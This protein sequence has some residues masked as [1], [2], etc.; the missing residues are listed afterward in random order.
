M[1]VVLDANIYVS[2]AISPSGLCSQIIERLLLK[3]K[4]YTIVISPKISKEIRA[5]LSKPYILKYSGRTSAELNRWIDM[6][7]FLALHVEDLPLTTI[8][9]R[10]PDDDKY[11]SAALNAQADC[12]ITGDSDLLVLKETFEI[13]I[14]SPRDFS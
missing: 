14:R 7:E 12:I 8:H 3:S 13:P 9:C 2:A 5:S 1:K 11:L 4:T 6:I 10:D